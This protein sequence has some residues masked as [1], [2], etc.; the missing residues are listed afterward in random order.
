MDGETI[1]QIER[2]AKD[3]LVVKSGGKE[4]SVHN[5]LPV[6][7]KRQASEIYVNSLSAIETYIKCNIDLLPKDKLFIHVADEGNVFLRSFLNEETRGRECFIHAEP[8][9]TRADFQY[10]TFLPLEQFKIALLSL[11]GQT[12]DR[13]RLIDFISRI[14]VKEDEVIEDDG[15]SQKVTAARQVGGQLRQQEQAPS[16]IKLKPFRT[17]T[18]VEQP[19]S[20]FVVRLKHDKYNGVTA[21]LFECDGGSWKKDAMENISVWLEESIGDSVKIIC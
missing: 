15:T 4:F 16:T 14:S 10:N 8:F 12:P 5:L 6:S 13:D 19:E 2:L 17:F 7:D 3:S 18:E 1:K 11:F 9:N 20:E 21:G